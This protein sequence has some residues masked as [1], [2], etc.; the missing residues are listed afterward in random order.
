MAT[1]YDILTLDEARA[2]V[3][4]P[5]ADYDYQ[6]ILMNTAV[7]QRFDDLCGPVVIQ[8]YVEDYDP[9]G[10]VFTLRHR[11]L[12]SVTYVKEAIFGNVTTL[13]AES[14]TTPGGYL[15]KP[16]EGVI[17]RR[18]QFFDYPFLGRVQVSYTAGRAT[19][20]ASVP[21][22]FKQAAAITLAHI[23]R[24]EQGSG[25]QTFGVAEVPA[26]GPTFSIPNRALELIAS[27]RLTPGIA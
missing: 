18:N 26:F 9:S 6:L 4:A 2:A 16:V 14:F 12:A 10:S 20:T 7:S 11:P 3:M 15:W 19:D 27:D 13:T 5:N 23:W 8:P 21:E 24:S 22:R 17:I 25:N 1:T